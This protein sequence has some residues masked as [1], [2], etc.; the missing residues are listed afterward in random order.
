MFKRTKLKKLISIVILGTMVVSFSTD[1]NKE[2][3]NGNNSQIENSKE[4]IE[5]EKEYYEVK[6]GEADIVEYNLGEDTIKQSYGQDMPYEING[7]IGV[8]KEGENHPI[9]YIM[10]G[11]HEIND[12]NNDRYD[13]GFKYLV[14]ELAKSGFLTVAINTNAQYVFEYGEP[15]AYERLNQIYDKHFESLK[16]A[17]N[18]G[19]NK[20]GVKLDKKGNINRVGLI[21]HSRGG[22][23]LDEIVSS[24][25]EKGNQNVFGMVKVA[26]SNWIIID[27]ANPDIP[28]AFIQPEYDGDV[29]GHDSQQSFDEIK[30]KDN[31]NSWVSMV[32]LKG[33]NH[34]FFNDNV[35][36]DDKRLGYADENHDEFLDRKGQ[37]EF[38]V[39]YSIDFLYKALGKEINSE[40]FD[41]TKSNIS[42]A[43]GF[44]I[45]SSF[46]SNEEELLL[47]ALDKESVNENLFGGGNTA[48]NLIIDYVIE[49]YIP[50][51]DQ[52]GIFNQGGNP[53]KMELLNITWDNKKGE[54]IL[55]ISEEKKDIS[56]FKSI[57]LYMGID[58]GNELNRIGENQS[59]SLVIKDG[60]GKE[61]TVI[62]DTKTSALNWP[63][64]K[65][66]DTDLGPIWSMPTSLSD[67]RI[68]LDKFKGVD[69]K[70]IDSI[71]LKFDQTKQGSLLIRDIRFM[72]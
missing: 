26:P 69:L 29:V 16:T 35:K 10:H 62:L 71:T 55:D 48:N 8:P 54:Y 21:G 34:N 65:I 56:E 68:S 45:K 6:K 37:K 43:Y 53:E 20:F 1:C 46:I 2:L 9:V 63:A 50:N 33:A 72:K 36:N 61:S 67:A 47:G 60:E 41:A 4:E 66:M 11:T 12:Y 3:S 39:N 7:V 58:P 23:S 14:E 17:I 52:L 57:S 70:N 28:T 24:Q 13:L 59:F 27:D 44:H 40:I 30:K 32:F 49:S 64:G 15:Y 22:L 31:F 5:D 38:L 18:G 19:E 51:D 25:K 42:K